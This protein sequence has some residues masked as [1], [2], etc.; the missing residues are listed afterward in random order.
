M[1]ILKKG[2][3]FKITRFFNEYFYN[4]YRHIFKIAKQIIKYGNKKIMQCFVTWCFENCIFW[5]LANAK[6]VDSL[7]FLSKKLNN[8]NIMQVIR[9]RVESEYK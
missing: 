6:I 8:D 2:N 5:M 3:I 7:E 4:S 1:V 9:E